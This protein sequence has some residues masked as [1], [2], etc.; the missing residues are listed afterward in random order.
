MGW[1]MQLFKDGNR[2]RF[3]YLLACVEQL[4]DVMCSLTITGGC[5]VLTRS[6]DIDKTR[7]EASVVAPGFSVNEFHLSSSNSPAASVSR[8]TGSH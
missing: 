2:S 5:L 4:K 7:D 1:S 6:F 8:R 3:Y